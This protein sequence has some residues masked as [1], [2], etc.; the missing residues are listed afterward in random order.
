VIAATSFDDPLRV[1][2]VGVGR[3]ALPRRF[4]DLERLAAFVDLDVVV[5]QVE[6]DRLKL[7]LACPHALPRDRGVFEL[8]ERVVGLAQHVLNP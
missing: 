3:P 5:R 4:Q 1:E 6:I 7:R 2:H 8:A